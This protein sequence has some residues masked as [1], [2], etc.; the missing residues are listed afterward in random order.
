[1]RSNVPSAAASAGLALTTE[2][3]C[4]DYGVDFFKRVMAA[5]AESG[6]PPVGLH[7]I[8]GPTAQ[9]KYSNAAKAVLNG[10]IAAWE[11]VFTKP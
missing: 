5:T 7:L 3:D 6:P 8:M 4:H 9:E 2:R 11:M 1:M 10:N